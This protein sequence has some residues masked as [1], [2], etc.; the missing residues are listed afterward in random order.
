M[1]SNLLND[2]ERAS[3][4]ATDLLIAGNWAILDTET[5]GLGPNAQICQLA[6]ITNERGDDW[7]TLVKPTVPISEAAFD[8]HGITD[9]LVKDA[10]RIDAVFLDLLRQIKGRDLAIYNAEFDL[11]LLKQSLRA[12]GIQVAFPTSDRRKCRIFTNGGS[13]HCAMLQYSAYV[14]EW[15]DR[16]QDYKWQKL[17]G[18]DHSALGDCHATRKV[19]ELMAD[20]GIL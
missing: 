8:V 14:G 4:W 6:L 5:T 12:V 9:A 3:R 10:P 19:I 11:K 1:T 13:I 20:G 16:H 17:P 15:S 7:Q 18:G 2:Q